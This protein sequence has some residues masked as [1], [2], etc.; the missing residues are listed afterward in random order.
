MI[1]VFLNNG[2][3]F[4]EVSIDA[5]TSVKI[6]NDN[7]PEFNGA[8]VVICLDRQSREVARFKWADVAGYAAGEVE[9]SG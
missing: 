7:G 6:L 5:A 3:E 1:N 9:V 2:R 4:Q 8:T